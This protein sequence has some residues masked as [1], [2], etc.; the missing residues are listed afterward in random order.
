MLN[1]IFHEKY[2]HK[3]IWIDPEINIKFVIDLLIG[4][5]EKKS[6]YVIYK[7]SDNH[8]ELIS[9]FIYDKI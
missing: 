8:H 1:T 5:I 4:K 3:L 2:I 6:K 7:F 9:H